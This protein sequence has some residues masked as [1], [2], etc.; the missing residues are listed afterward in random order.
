MLSY[1]SIPSVSPPPRAFD[2]VV[3]DMDGV[4]TDTA[5]VHARAWKRM[6]D[7]YLAHRAAVPAA[8][9]AGA[10]RARS[11]ASTS[12]KEFSPADYRAYVDGK[13]RYDGVA[14]FLQARGISLP[15]GTPTDAAGSGTVCGLGNRKNVLFNQLLASDGVQ[16]FP[17]TLALIHGLRRQGVRVGLAT[18][19]RNADLILG[20]AQIRG[21][22]A[23]VVDG[24][25]AERM[26]LRGKPAPDI[27]AA[28]CTGLGVHC[29]RAIIVEDAV[30]GVRAGAA[31]GFGLV[32][33]VARE[34]NA[35]ELR[36]NGADVVVTDL[37]EIS[38]E[39]LAARVRAKRE[40]GR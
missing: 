33:G 21:L 23:T 8:C 6:F 2:A 5:S 37:G 11:S 4:V 1:P 34:D 9:E 10:A 12:F 16:V 32:V 14:A 15:R 24:L 3:F 29:S 30:S 22:F 7:E 39:V 38:V 18:S 28:A 19:S 20:R 27:F 31:G 17:A 13:P 26:Q 40:G 36:D 25:V 35:Q